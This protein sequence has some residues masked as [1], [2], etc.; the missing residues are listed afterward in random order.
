MASWENCHAAPSSN[1][2]ILT[3]QNSTQQLM[4]FG[5][6]ELTSLS[7][8]SLLRIKQKHV[9]DFCLENFIVI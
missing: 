9:N 8:R 1:P 3:E 4:G 7:P 6:D 5:F 2:K